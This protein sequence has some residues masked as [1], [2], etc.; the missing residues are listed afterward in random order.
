M[1]RRRF[2]PRPG[3]K[4]SSERGRRSVAKAP[5]GRVVSSSTEIPGSTPPGLGGG[6]IACHIKFSQQSRRW[7]VS[8][9]SNRRRTRRVLTSRLSW[10][11]SGSDSSGRQ[12]LIRM[13]AHGSRSIL[14]PPWLPGTA[15]ICWPVNPGV[16]GGWLR[17]C[18]EVKK[19]RGTSYYPRRSSL[20]PY[21]CS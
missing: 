11:G 2:G 3:R 14:V 6:G 9:R 19:E 20:L 4:Q 5:G 16:V 12:R 21:S 18:G 15:P 8:P 10:D 13:R 17:G 7:G 1:S